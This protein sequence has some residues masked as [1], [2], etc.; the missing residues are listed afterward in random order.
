MKPPP[1]AYAA[2]STLENACG[3]LAADDDAKILAGGQ[4]LMPL[5][6]IRLAVPSTLVDLARVPGL[7]RVDEAGAYVRFGAMVTHARVISDPIT[8]RRVP[9]MVEAGRHIAH[10]QIRSRG[11][12]GGSIAHG[13]NAG[14]WPLALLT[15][16]GMVE[17]ES[18]RGRRTVDVDDLFLSPYVTA[19]APDEILTDVWVQAAESGWGF[20]EVARRAGDYGLALVGANLEFDEDVCTSAR[21]TVGAACGTVLRIA[22]A[23]QVLTGSRVTQESADAAADAAAETLTFLEDIHGGAEYRKRVV[24]GLVGRVVQQAGANR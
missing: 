9:M 22:A 24:R 4:S 15:L 10:A 8:A 13:D 17:A 5:L 7:A 6:A 12:L 1:L 23:E 3:L 11:T 16:G 14:E 19:L 20:A 18:V 21:V 2:P